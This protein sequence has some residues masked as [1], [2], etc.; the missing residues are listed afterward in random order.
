MKKV[1]LFHF[2][3]CPFC[4]YAR[5]WIEEARAENPALRAVEIE[6]IDERLQPGIA[7]RYDY[8][9]VPTFYVDGKK[10]HEGACTKDKVKRILESCLYDG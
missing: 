6:L 5:R 7:W 2:E 8:W 10:V 9:Y 4:R 3:S 1:V